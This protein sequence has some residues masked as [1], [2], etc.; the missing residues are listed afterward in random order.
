[1]A[2][3][4]RARGRRLAHGRAQGSRHRPGRAH[5]H[6]RNDGQRAKEQVLPTH[7]ACL[8][9]FVLLGHD[10][11]L[12]NFQT[13]ISNDAIAREQTRVFFTDPACLHLLVLLGDGLDLV[14]GVP[15][16]VHNH[17]FLLRDGCLR[18]R[19]CISHSH[20]QKDQIQD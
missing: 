17:S 6:I 1:V 9:L 4:G 16:P 19:V 10:N 12:A 11:I 2:Q 13:S 3:K 7:Q 5:T 14:G 18:V 15:I 8:K 20:Q